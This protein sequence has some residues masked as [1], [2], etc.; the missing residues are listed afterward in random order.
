MTP[1]SELT[2]FF[3]E[4]IKEI[5]EYLALL[6]AIESESRS[7]TPRLEQTGIA[8][9]VSQQRILS[10]S[11]YLQLYNL[12][13]AMVT[14]CL[15]ALALTFEEG[16]WQPADL[17][18]KLRQ[19]WVRFVARP[20]I[21]MGPENRLKNAMKMCDHLLE[22]LPLHGFK[23]DAGGGG[24]WD[25]EAIY[26]LSDRVGCS[27]TLQKSTTA[28]VKRPVRDGLGALQLVKDRRNGLAHGSIS[29]IDCADGV[30]VSELVNITDSTEA[31]LRE[32]IAS[33]ISFIDTHL[34]LVESRRPSAGKTAS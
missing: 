25:D 15:D 6:Q 1:T 28:A 7:G 5:R 8:I 20:H 2:P 21:D 26:R 18:L 11:V 27:L 29:F 13:E 31:Y 34:F 14:K 24:N 23:I 12:T 16:A 4:R 19:E 33:F 17:E 9:T 3:D 32:V 10:S 22:S 30:A